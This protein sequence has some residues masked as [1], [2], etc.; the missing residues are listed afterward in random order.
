MAHNSLSAGQLM[1]FLVASQGVQRS[2]AQGSILLGTVIRGMTAGARVFEYLAIEP[3]IDLIT[4]ATI[5]FDQL[6]GEIRFENVTF[7][8]PSRPDQIILR[9]FNLTLKPGQTVALV[10]ASGSGK[11]TIASLIERFYEPNGGQITLDGTP[12]ASLSPYWLRA[13]VIG[14]IEQQPVLF[15][16]TIFENI[17]Y[18]RPLATEAEIYAAAKL[19]QSHDFV[20]EL[21]DGYHTNVGERGTQLSGGQRQRI[22]IA[23]AL[24]KQPLILIL[25][26]ATR[27]VSVACVDQSKYEIMFALNHL[28]RIGCVQR[29]HSTKGSRYGHH[30]SDD[31]H[32]CPS[33]VNDSQCGFDCGDGPR[34]NR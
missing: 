18:G 12:I 29:S 10:G 16:T 27:Y 22:A 4:G 31:T 19:A 11:S 7:A 20:S 21:S 28:Q 30:G 17:R 34:A 5:P 25:D 8:Y 3:K 14:L 13:E 2:L 23:R 15:G 32:H 33:S 6:A 24:L 26:E 1:A 9:N